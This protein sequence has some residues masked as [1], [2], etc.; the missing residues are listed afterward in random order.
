MRG[1]AAVSIRKKTLLDRL[2]IFRGGNM[3]TDTRAA[4]MAEYA[5]IAAIVL[6]AA[7]AGF[8]IFGQKLSN[9][10]NGANSAWN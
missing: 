7:Y 1:E 2:F 9:A 8:R 5:I 3:L 4:N 10:I 6:I